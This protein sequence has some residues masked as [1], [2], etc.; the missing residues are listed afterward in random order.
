MLWDYLR[1]VSGLGLDVPW[2]VVGDFNLVIS[3]SKKK[4]GRPPCT[5]GMEEFRD[6]ID[7]CSLTDV[8]FAG[9]KFTWCNNQR[10]ED[11]ILA[12]LD[13]CL[14][15]ARSSDVNARFHHLPR[16]ASDHAPLLVDFYQ[17]DGCLSR[18]NPSGT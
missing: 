11:R 1:E 6:Y 2:S 3:C 7:G 9:P 8:G 13:R 5:L 15:S 17:N 14:L 12:R 10:G 18:G 16:I 4:G